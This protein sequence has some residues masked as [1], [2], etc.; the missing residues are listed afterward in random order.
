MELISNAPVQK[1][2]SMPDLLKSKGIY[3]FS[4]TNAVLIYANANAFQLAFMIDTATITF[5]K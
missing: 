2:C 3:L 1:S 4:S 5:P